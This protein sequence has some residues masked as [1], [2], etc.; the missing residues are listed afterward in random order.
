[1]QLYARTHF[2]P[3]FHY[4]D[5]L[6]CN[7]QLHLQHF[8]SLQCSGTAQLH[9]HDPGVQGLGYDYHRHHDTIAGNGCDEKNSPTIPG[10]VDFQLVL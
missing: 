10:L 5:H 4:L 8:P 1:M 2:T 9:A 7:A 3:K 6:S